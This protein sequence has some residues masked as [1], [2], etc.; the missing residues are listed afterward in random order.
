[1]RFKLDSSFENMRIGI[2]ACRWAA[3]DIYIDGNYLTSY[4]TTGLN[5]K[6]Y[7]ENRNLLIDI[8]PLPIETGKEHVLAVHVI[9]HVAPLSPRFLKTE[10]LGTSF[11]S[12]IVL[13]GPLAYKKATGFIRDQIG[14]FFLYSGVIG[15]LSIL[16][17]FLYLQNRSEKNILFISVS[18]SLFFSW[19]LSL[20]IVQYPLELDFNRWWLIF[21]IAIQLWPL[22]IAS[23][24][25]TVGEIF[26]FKY[27]RH[28]SFLESSS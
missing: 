10:S 11:G 3:V 19:P 16:F 8:H 12:L 1:M 13:T 7:E 23:M 27:K 5:G 28:C 15:F 24:V 18:T 22:A 20:T 9:D 14:Y 21:F 25:Y 26:S 2:L 17:W 6:P 4:G